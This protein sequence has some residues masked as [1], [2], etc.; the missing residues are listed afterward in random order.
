MFSAKFKFAVPKLRLPRRKPQTSADEESKPKDVSH[1]NHATTTFCKVHGR[2]MTPGQTESAYCDDLVDAF[3]HPDVLDVTR[4][5]GTIKLAL[6]AHSTSWSH[7]PNGGPSR[8]R[9]GSAESTCPH[10]HGFSSSSSTVTLVET[11]CSDILRGLSICGTLGRGA[12]G[13]V[14]RARV[15]RTGPLLALKVIAKRDA[16]IFGKASVQNEQAALARLVDLPGVLQLESSFHDDMNYYIIT[17]LHTHGDL[18]CIL[19]YRGCLPQQLVQFYAADLILTLSALH[20]RGI[21]H[22]DIKPANIL[23]GSDGHLV[24][25]DFGLAKVFPT[26]GN[27][28]IDVT[29]YW[30]I[31]ARDGI[32]NAGRSRRTAHTSKMYVTRGSCGSPAYAAPERMYGFKY[33]FEVDYWS[34]GVVVYEMLTGRVPWF[35]DDLEILARQVVDSP[36]RFA[37]EWGI[38]PVAKDFLHRCLRKPPSER[39]GVDDMKCHPFFDDFDWPNMIDRLL[40]APFIPTQPVNPLANMP[41][42]RA[43]DILEVGT[44]YL[45]MGDYDN[46]IMNGGTPQGPLD[47]CPDFAYQSKSFRLALA[48]RALGEVKAAMAVRRCSALTIDSGISFNL[49]PSLALPSPTF[50][51]APSSS[52]SRSP[53]VVGSFRWGSGRS[54]G[55]KKSALR[56][57]TY[58]TSQAP[59][60]AEL[61]SPSSPFPTMEEKDNEG[62]DSPITADEKPD[63]EEK[64]PRRQR[65][66][67]VGAFVRS[68]VASYIKRKPRLPDLDQPLPEPDPEP[69][70]VPDIPDLYVTEPTPPVPGTPNRDL[71]R[72]VWDTVPISPETR[73]AP[74]SPLGARDRRRGQSIERDA[75]RERM[76][77]RRVVEHDM[78]PPPPRERA[79]H[80]GSSEHQEQEL[81]ERTSSSDWQ[82]EHTQRDRSSSRQRGRAERTER[83]RSRERDAQKEWDGESEGSPGGSIRYAATLITGLISSPKTGTTRSRTQRSS[84]SSFWCAG[85]RDWKTPSRDSRAGF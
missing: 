68:R 33:G 24:V 18:E 49:N 3:Y 20:A 70:V 9:P 47:P 72:S 42:K 82:H 13:T 14:H 12:S 37:S 61:P 84:D 83:T 7:L 67:S 32:A 55:G 44:P 2:R 30:L 38:D 60:V 74:E 66:H 79:E 56:L 77:R 16:A 15:G 34:L 23:V 76:A 73:T 54:K 39:L 62:A 1:V 57:S 6:K 85:D 41:S 80:L 52:G 17:S 63:S 36:L 51:E 64:V 11:P 40:P 27:Q 50:S 26:D 28:P 43:L 46:Q 81:P 25:A 48:E 29:P 53:T 5:I 19:R 31:E 10:S 78:P 71:D 35:H 59:S 22:R 21:I 4:E 8:C 69:G 75:R 58:F 45:S 65:L